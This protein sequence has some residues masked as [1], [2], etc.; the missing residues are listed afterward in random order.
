MSIEIDI[1]ATKI[2]CKFLTMELS[3]LNL[4]KYWKGILLDHMPALSMMIPVGLD[5]YHFS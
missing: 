1:E 2:L 3:L 5:Y 4:R